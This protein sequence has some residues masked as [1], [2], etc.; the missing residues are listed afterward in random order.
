MHYGKERNSLW[1]PLSTQTWNSYSIQGYDKLNETE[2]TV[3][4]WDQV[5]EGTLFISFSH[6]F[7][8]LKKQKNI[9]NYK[10]CSKD[11]YIQNILDIQIKKRLWNPKEA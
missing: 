2:I 1:W 10:R 9:L 7:N 11:M 5:I 3:V 8:H 4:A 6:W